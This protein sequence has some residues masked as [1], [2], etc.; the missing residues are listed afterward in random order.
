MTLGEQQRKFTLYVSKLIEYAYMA[1]Y[2]LTF[3]DAY[4]SPEQA[5][6]NAAAGKGISNSLHTQ[7]LAIDLNLF[8]DGKYLVKSEDYKPLGDF[9]KTLHP[10]CCWGGDF[11]PTADGNHFSMTYGGRK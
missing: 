10:L 11:K 6:A 9:W 8:K 5:Q 4:R 7:R 3:G 2:E 1:G